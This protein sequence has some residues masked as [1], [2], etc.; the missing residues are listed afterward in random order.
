MSDGGSQRMGSYLD[1][2]RAPPFSIFAKGPF[3]T[4][5]KSPKALQNLNL[6]PNPL[7]EAPENSYG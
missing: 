2:L 1:Y 3:R 6:S 7:R 4:L 5:P